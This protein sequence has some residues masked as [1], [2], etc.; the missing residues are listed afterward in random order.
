MDYHN[1]LSERGMVDELQKQ[2]NWMWGIFEHALIIFQDIEEGFLIYF[3]ILHHIPEL[4]NEE[5]FAKYRRGL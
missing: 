3:D 1:T 5:D 2:M 4:I